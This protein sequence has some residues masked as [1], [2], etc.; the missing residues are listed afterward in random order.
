M[1]QLSIISHLSSMIEKSWHCHY[2]DSYRNIFL[3]V[4]N[5]LPLNNAIDEYVCK[6]EK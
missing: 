5:A 3:G 2:D 6:G 1:A 4:N